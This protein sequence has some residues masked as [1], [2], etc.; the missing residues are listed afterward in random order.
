MLTP[1]LKMIFSCVTGKTAAD[2]GTDHGYIPIEL[3]KS[4]KC[5]KVIATDLCAGPISIAEKNI[6][7]ENLDIETR[8]G[9]GLSVIKE[10]EVEDII[11]AG[12]G[13]KLIVNILS[14][15]PKIAKSG[16]LILQPMNGQY[17]LRKFLSEKGYSVKYEDIAVEGNKVYN[18]IVCG[19]TENPLIYKEEI[20][21]HLPGFLKEHKLYPMLLEKKIRE[22]TKITDGFEKSKEMTE[23]EKIKY[24]LYKNFLEVRRK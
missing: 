2:I 18:A 21:Y 23:K 7:A 8:I 10:G 4:G 11:I 16:N 12:M 9:N 19:K 5:S 13:G 24:T 22:F 20:D 1:R 17:E 14:S 6:K 15:S 3:I